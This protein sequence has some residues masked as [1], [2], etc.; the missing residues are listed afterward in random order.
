MQNKIPLVI[1]MVKVIIRD[2]GRLSKGRRVAGAAPGDVP[3]EPGN[4]GRLH[5]LKSPDFGLWGRWRVRIARR[6]G[7][8]EFGDCLA[9]AFRVGLICA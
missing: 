2:L 3:G 8:R 1:T 4:G 6:A 5:R 9:D 7:S